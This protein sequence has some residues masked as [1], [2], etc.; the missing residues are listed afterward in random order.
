MVDKFSV[1]LSQRVK[2]KYDKKNLRSISFIPKKKKYMNRDDIQKFVQEKS[3]AIA[4][5]APGQSFAIL[6]HYEGF[7]H[8]MSGKFTKVGDIVKMHDVYDDHEDHA[9]KSFSIQYTYE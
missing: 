5:V 8:P 7:E 3:N 4:D 1:K 2:I 9:I 6:L